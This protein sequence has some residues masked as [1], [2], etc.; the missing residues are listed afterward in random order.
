MKFQLFIRH[1]L[2]D[3]LNVH[4]FAMFSFR[5][6]NDI[7]SPTLNQKQ[8]NDFL[9]INPRLKLTNNKLTCNDQVFGLVWSSDK[10]I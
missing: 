3:T 8:F 1:D 5:L 4:D 7:V 6:N 9:K 2:F 10:L